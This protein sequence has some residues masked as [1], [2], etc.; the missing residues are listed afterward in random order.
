M[1]RHRPVR[2]SSDNRYITGD[3]EPIPQPKMRTSAPLVEAIEPV[4][5]DWVQNNNW[6][7]SLDMLSGWPLVNSPTIISIAQNPVFRGPPRGRGVLLTRQDVA[8]QNASV[9]LSI[10]ARITLGLGGMSRQLLVDW[11]NVTTLNLPA[12]NITVEVIVTGSNDDS[13]GNKTWGSQL[14]VLF[15]N[16]IVPKDGYNTYT[17]LLNIHNNAFTPVPQF[18]KGFQFTNRAFTYG[19]GQ[20]LAFN[21]LNSS[22]PNIVFDIDQLID[23]GPDTIYWLPSFVSQCTSSLVSDPAGTALISWVLSV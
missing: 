4:R 20:L 11:G 19:A 14:D 2:S 21:G 17:Q 1:A 12:S 7:F 9:T 18:A 22:W 16:E 5:G 8:L 10:Q 3:I 23:N 6:G 13:F 15:S